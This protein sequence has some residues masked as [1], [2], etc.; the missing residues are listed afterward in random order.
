MAFYSAFKADFLKLWGKLPAEDKVVSETLSVAVPLVNDLLT[1]GDPAVEAEVA[2]ILA[3]VQAKFATVSTLV[4]SAEA[5]GTL[6]GA[7]TSLQSNIGSILSLASVKNSS[8]QATVTTTVGK[9]V[10]L[11]NEIE[12]DFPK[13]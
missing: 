2:P 6:S 1:I 4:T 7:V 12:A 13:L 5:P 10:S 11:L 9:L 3:I 8:K